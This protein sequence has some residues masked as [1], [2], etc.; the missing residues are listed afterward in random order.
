MIK[1]SFVTVFL[2]LVITSFFSFET[3]HILPASQIFEFLVLLSFFFVAK[4]VS[5]TAFIIFILTSVYIIY[6]LYV[7]L[8]F[9]VYPKDYFIA[10][11]AFFYLIILSFF[12]GKELFS[13]DFVCKAY[14]FLLFAFIIKYILWLLLATFKRPGLFYENNFELMFLLLFTIAVYRVL[15]KLKS[16]DLFLLVC[17]VFLSGSRSGILSLIAILTILYIKNF[18][19]KTIIKLIMLSIIALGGAAVFISRLGNG[20]IESVDRF[21]FLQAF[22]FSV[23]DWGV[24]DFLTGSKP[25]TA[26]PESVCQT[27]G[28]YKQLFSAGDPSK[29]YSVILHSYILRAIFDQG[30]LGL[31][32][33]F[34]A[35]AKLLSVSNVPPRALLAVMAILLINALSVSSIS[36]VFAAL[37]LIVVL[38]TRYTKPEAI[39]EKVH[40]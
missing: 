27:F 1:N 25:L 29:C 4:R 20:G 36:S 22:V 39:I 38:A 37:G 10:Y 6:T 17:V 9:G 12:A 28:F 13:A 16:L 5:I 3:Y 19:L 34:Y 18:D 15:G 14:R 35:V 32:F 24:L 33:V 40:I 2:L 21:A 26:L 8:S 7:S 11:K 23:I 30:V 31:L